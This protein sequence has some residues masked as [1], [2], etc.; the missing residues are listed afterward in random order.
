MTGVLPRKPSWLDQHLDDWVDAGI[1]DDAQREAIEAYERDLG[2]T[3]DE[4][5]PRRLSIG[6]EVAAYIG[7]VLAL[8]GGATAV[9]DSWEDWSFGAR[10]ALALVLVAVGL[11]IGH[12]LFRFGE[13]GTDRVAGFVTTLGVGGIALAT[14]LIVDEANDRAEVWI[15]WSV[16]L[17]VLI[18][19][20]VIWRNRDRPMQL[21]TAIVGFVFAG[22]A[23]ADLLDERFWMAGLVF[24]AAGITLAVLGHLE[25][26][27]PPL[28]ALAGGGVGAYIGAYMLA[29]L[30]RHLGPSVALAIALLFVL[31]AVRVDLTLL[32]VAAILGA[33]IASG[34]LL[35]TTFESTVSALGVAVIG[36]ALVGVVISRS[37]RREPT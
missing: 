15:P 19:S 23:T 6:A 26:A 37:A 16:G 5:R 27:N 4:A 32:L 14:G 20:L 34:A 11:G 36:L 25:W 2:P 17:A 28:I 29:D 35:S 22:I 10:L 7:S 3:A 18:A 24:V 33:T 31:Y 30:N 21:A 13:A 8:T 12:W 1:V 9:G